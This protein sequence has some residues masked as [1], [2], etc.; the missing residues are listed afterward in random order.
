MI[1]NGAVRP[2]KQD[3]WATYPHER[4]ALFEFIGK[5]KISG[6]ILVGGDVHRTRVLRHRTAKVAGYR[7]PELI[8]SPIHGGVIENAKAP[9]P[10]L[11]HDSGKP[12]TFLLMTVR[13]NSQ[14]A[15]LNARFLDKD[16]RAFHEVTFQDRE[17]GK[18]TRR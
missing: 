16:G 17:L 3:H 10:A 15:T 6:V 8:T 5:E 12:N 1:W 11:V 7:I 2:G 14:P 13:S 18:K 9:H 4:Q